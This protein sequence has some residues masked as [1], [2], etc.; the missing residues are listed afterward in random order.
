MFFFERTFQTV[1]NGVSGAL[2][3]MGAITGIAN[4]VLLLCAL[5]AVYE[6]YARGGDARMIGIAAAKFLLLGLVLSN[7]DT[8]FR[9]VNGTFNQVAAAISPNDWAS[10]AVQAKAG[11]PHR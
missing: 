3:P 1:L 9:S 6:A 8:I 2:G 10:S 7:Y 4:A 11:F 5:F